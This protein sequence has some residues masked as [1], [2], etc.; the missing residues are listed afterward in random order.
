MLV[1][2][3]NFLPVIVF[4]VS[5]KITTNL[6]LATALIIAAC[7]ISTALEFLI[8]K[9]ISRI[10]I[11]MIAAVLIFGIP[12]VLLKDPSIIKW[13]V[14]VVNFLLAAAIFV[15]QF[16]LKKNPFSYLLGHEIKLPE[17]AFASMSRMWMVF[18]VF[19]GL[20]NI[21]IAFYLPELFG[22][23]KE[24]A[25]QIWVDYKSFGNAILNFLFALVCI[26]ILLKKYPDALKEELNK[27]K[28]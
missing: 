27:N 18:F 16:I 6:V 7:I 22:F 20:L 3:L 12:T 15:S 14:T 8:T 28:N 2:I 21:V 19:S 10:Q 25:E 23:T 4:F 11:F 1:K 13:K 5:Y 17:E 9:S 24:Y 26:F